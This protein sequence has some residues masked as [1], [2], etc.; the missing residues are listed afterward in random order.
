MSSLE[1]LPIDI[2]FNK[3]QDWL[4]NRR[5]CIQE[6]QARAVIIREKINEALTDMPKS[7]QILEL[8]EGTYVTYF[9][10]KKIIELLKEDEE[11]GK[12]NVFGQYSSQ[13]MKDWSEIIKLYEKDGVYLGE[14]AQ[15]LARNVNYEVPALKRQIAKCQ[16]IKKEC[17]RKQTDYTAKAEELRKKYDA[18]CKQMGIEGKK[19]KTELAALVQDLPAEFQK[20]SE[21]ASKLTKS[22]QYYDEFVDFLANESETDRDSLPVLKYIM[23]KGNTTTY[24][25]RTGEK[26]EVIEEAKIFIDTSDETD[27]MQVTDDIDWGDPGSMTESAI[28]FGDEIDFSMADITVETGGTEEGDENS[29]IDFGTKEHDSDS[30]G[31][32]WNEVV[33]VNKTDSEG[34]AK[35]EDA[36]SILDNPR[37]RVLFIDDLMELEAFLSQRLFELES[38]SAGGDVLSSSQMQDAPSSIQL[39]QDTVTGMISQ[40]RDII[41]AFSTVKM[42]H[43]LSIR[44]SPRYVDRLKETL[45]QM[46]NLADKMVFLE[47]EMVVKHKDA[48]VEQS[49][50]QPKLELVIRRTKEMQKQMESDISRRYKDRVVNI[51]GEINTM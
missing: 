37:T 24:Q 26:P 4:I 36:M 47:K 13:R 48:D 41:A 29:E 45:K 40:V 22:V 42:H 5:H 49:E 10:S 23:E 32:D 16:Q 1:N 43:L 21:S 19:I 15:M 3:L 8:L 12:K 44:N 27:V 17:E 38:D 25:W 30:N 11:S 14:A 34:V 20:I 31:I 46:L 9:H 50:T 39:P 7:S 6:W 35:G 2:H 28:D 33:I 18:T 51:M